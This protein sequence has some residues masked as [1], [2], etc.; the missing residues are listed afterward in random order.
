MFTCSMR[1]ALTGLAGLTVLM[2]ASACELPIRIQAPDKPIE[3][4][5]NIKIDQEIRV[6]LDKDVED[7][8]SDNPDIF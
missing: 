5:L 7:L 6:R 1:S 4:N 2:G 8:I 3:I